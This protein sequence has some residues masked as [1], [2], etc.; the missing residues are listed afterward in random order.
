M[1]GIILSNR[2]ENLLRRGLDQASSETE[3]RLAAARLF[4]SLRKRGIDGY[5]ILETL[6]RDTSPDTNSSASRP[7][8]TQEQPET[9]PPQQPKTQTYPGSGNNTPPPQ[10][11][12]PPPPQ[13]TYWS[14]APPKPAH[15]I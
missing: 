5:Q 11:T 9:Q 8:P 6:A 12:P 15:P 1:T 14:E 7:K 4:D 3:A 2:E 13:W 10:W